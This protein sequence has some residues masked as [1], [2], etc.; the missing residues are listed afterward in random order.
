M[1]SAS[2]ELSRFGG[3]VN[4]EQG[5]LL[6]TDDIDRVGGMAIQS[7]LAVLSLMFFDDENGVP[8]SGFPR[9]QL[10]TNHCVVSSTGALS[11]SVSTGIGF[12]YNSAAT[13]DEFGPARYLPIVLDTAY[14]GSL[15]A[16][17]ATNP[18]IDIVCIAPQFVGDQA[19]S[20]NVKSPSTG[21]MAPTSVA[22]RLRFSAIVQVVTGT[23]AASPTAPAV[24]AGYMEIGRALVPATTGSASWEDTRQCLELGHYF[25]GLPRHAVAN[26]VPLGGTAELEVTATSPVSL[27]VYVTRGRAVINGVMRSYKARVF[28]PVTL[29]AADPVLDRIDLIVAKQD[30]TIAAVTGTPGSASP[31]AAPAASVRLAAVTVNGAATTVTSGDIE[32]LRPREPFDGG[33]HLQ[34]QSV[35]WDRLTAPAIMAQATG[36]AVVSGSVATI[37]FDVLNADEGT[38]LQAVNPNTNQGYLFV[39]EAWTKTDTPSLANEYGI[40]APTNIE[41]MTSVDAA[42]FQYALKG[43]SNV[44]DT[45]NL[46]TPRMVFRVDDLTQ[47]VE[48]SVRRRATAGTLAVGVHIYPLDAPGM[49]FTVTATFT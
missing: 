29:A 30:G 33:D 3:R 8:L 49:G 16:H 27:G 43:E 9:E 17:D 28:P 5:Q 47:P 15:A 23:P 21:V 22:Q 32:D 19:A 40:V 26:Y 46:Y 36:P 20:R 44:T 1:A 7:L 13:A 2:L 38:P 18:R 45:T 10:A 41:V 35:P 34:A 48:I 6:L 14:T 31:P 11:F 12:F 4:T 42:T 39:A 25:K 37:A 24:P